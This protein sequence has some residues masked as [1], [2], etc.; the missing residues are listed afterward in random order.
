MM[1]GGWWRAMQLPWLPQWCPSAWCFD[2]RLAWQ[3][4]R[5]I[6]NIFPS[7]SIRLNYFSISD[8]V[9]CW[10]QVA[11]TSFTDTVKLTVT[12]Y[13]DGGR[14]NKTEVW[15]STGYKVFW[16]SVITVPEP[17]L[18]WKLIKVLICE[19]REAIMTIARTLCPIMVQ[20][21]HP[22]TCQM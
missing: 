20:R 13:N 17:T 2:P 14:R 12:L 8:H 10:T 9:M 4:N 1:C 21:L 15:C 7:I 6:P 16:A 11:T 19:V 18:F 3:L 22:S 5:T